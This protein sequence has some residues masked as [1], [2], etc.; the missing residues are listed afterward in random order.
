MGLVRCLLLPC[1]HCTC[2]WRGCTG[3]ALSSM[4][5]SLALGLPVWPHPRA[6]AGVPLPHLPAY[7][8]LHPWPP[9]LGELT[10]QGTAPS[11][12]GSGAWA[13]LP[14]LSR[15]VAPHSQAEPR[16]DSWIPSHTE[17]SPPHPEC[18]SSL[19]L[20]LQLLWRFLSVWV[21]AL[22]TLGSVPGPLPLSWGLPNA[23]LTSCTP[24][25]I[26]PLTLTAWHLH[27][28]LSSVSAAPRPASL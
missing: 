10:P 20:F 24:C 25:I 14:A 26:C 2:M 12:T 27:E 8:P 6:C 9:G 11:R 18:F 17:K 15:I 3:V 28:G 23:H 13:Q 16:R 19:S 5:P 4:C 7:F 1:A 21:S 22:G